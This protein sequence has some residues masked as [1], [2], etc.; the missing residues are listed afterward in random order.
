MSK[1]LQYARLVTDYQDF[2]DS[3]RDSPD[4]IGAVFGASWE[5]VHS[6]F[7][8]LDRGIGI[9]EGVIADL[10]DG[11]V[12]AES[13]SFLS[14]RSGVLS[15]ASVAKRLIPALEKAETGMQE[16]YDA[17]KLPPLDYEDVKSLTRPDLRDQVRLWKENM[18]RLKDFVSYAQQRKKLKDL[19]LHG[20]AAAADTWPYASERL[21]DYARLCWAS[22]AY[23][24]ALKQNP[25]L[26]Q[27][28]REL[29]ERA[30]DKFGKGDIALLEENRFIVAREHTAG[31]PQFPAGQLK[32]LLREFEKRR[33]HLP[34]RQLMSYA[35][36]AVQRIK[37]LL[38]MSPLSVATYLPPGSI[39]FDLVVFDEASQIRPIDAFGAILRS[40]QVVVVGDKQQLPPTKFFEIDSQSEPLDPEDPGESI[41][42]IESILGLASAQGCP[43]SMLNWHYRSRHESLIAVSNEEFYESQLRVFPSPQSTRGGNGLQF[44]FV[45]SSEYVPGAMGR[46]NPAEAKEVARQVLRHVRESPEKSLGIASF[47]SGQRDRILEEIELLR[48]DSGEVDAFEARHPAEPLFVKNLEN[49]QGDERDVVFVSVGYGRKAD[50]SLSHNFGPINRPGG[51]RRLNVIFTRARERCVLFANFRHSDLDPDRSSSRGMRVLRRYMQFAE[52]VELLT[53][54]P[55][56]LGAGDRGASVALPSESAF[57]RS[58]GAMLSARGHAVDRAVGVS[59]I[60]IDLAVRSRTRPDE[61]VLGIQCDGPA[62]HDSPWPRG[63]DRLGKDVLHRKGWNTLRIWAPDWMHDP[64]AELKRIE[65]VLDSIAE[66]G[67][68]QTKSRDEPRSE[69]DRLTAVYEVGDPANGTPFTSMPYRRWEG[70]SSISHLQLPDVPVGKLSDLVSAIVAVESPI[71]SEEIMRRLR[72]A[73]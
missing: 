69:E 72:D 67:S 8:L 42:D 30:I 17:L 53:P 49:V 60:R 26:Q 41:S 11:R 24:T 23:R 16:L 71:H 52:A 7:Q 27:F 15:A 59:E 38:M 68:E 34:V 54:A 31:M 6:D 58:V 48:R 21:S 29:H 18:S 66:L 36:G 51:A 4:S 65:T 40:K 13:I 14:D 25:N 37:P 2:T 46:F 50:G 5:G 56:P 45:R 35:G 28:S 9:I 63:R 39:E 57:A 44:R 1:L 47:G 64:E 73:S 20:V 12:S 32:V 43:S 61:Y 62:Y 70:D 22:D 19:G 55:E 10:L 3:I 33:N